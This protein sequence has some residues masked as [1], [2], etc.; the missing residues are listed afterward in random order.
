MF[1]HEQMQVAI[2]AIKELAA[3]VGNPAWDWTPPTANTA[4]AAGAGAPA[5][6]VERSWQQTLR[7]RV[8]MKS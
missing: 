8:L 1:G 4:L 5:D 3:E 7:S 6:L 2:Q